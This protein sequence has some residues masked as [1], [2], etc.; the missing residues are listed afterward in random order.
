MPS[1]RPVRPLDQ[2][3]LVKSLSYCHG[4]AHAFLAAR[5]VENRRKNPGPVARQVPAKFIQC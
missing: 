4:F 5:S 3:E 1:P 2:A